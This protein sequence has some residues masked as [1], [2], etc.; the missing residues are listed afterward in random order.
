MEDK[1][2]IFIFFVAIFLL[3]G[4][5]CAQESLLEL[6][7]GY[8][9]DN[10]EGEPV[11]K[12]RLVWDDDEY[13]S[14]YEVEIQ[15]FSTQY[16][17]YL[18][19]TTNEFFIEISLRP[20]KYRYCVTPYDLLGNRCESSDWEEFTVDQAFQPE[21]IKIV[22]ES[23]YM[24]QT[25]DRVLLI[26]GN[27]I[28]DD[29]EIYLRNGET[30]LL[31]IS[32]TVT[33]NSSVKLTFND[34]AL[35]PGTYDI[36]IKNPGGLEV[37]KDGFII[38]YA[39][40]FETFIKLGYNPVIPLFGGFNDIFGSYFYFPGV[41]LRIESLSSARAS[42]KAGLEFAVSLYYLNNDYCIKPLDSISDDGTFTEAKLTLLDFTL[43]VSFQKR[44][45]HLKNAITFSFGFGITSSSIEDYSYYTDSYEYDYNGINVHVNLGLSGLFL[46]YKDLYVETGVEV[47]YYIIGS[48][49]MIKPKIS[50]VYRF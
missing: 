32:K 26:S 9:I 3:S 16:N 7:S 4:L 5:L 2:N 34:D 15:L 12:Q 28:F 43:N 29:S 17:D 36:Y 19:K 46:C 48:S 10:N 24:D 40:R 20:G 31:P 49:F 23:F 21:I 8:Y 41:T 11:F 30:V 39:K 45:N 42:F 22:P 27:N 18:T 33:N 47:T 38:G 50:L 25:K 35:I 6:K 44:Y 1:K 37:I 14:Y 13:A